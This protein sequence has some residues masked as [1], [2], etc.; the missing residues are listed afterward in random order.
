MA[1]SSGRRIESL[2]LALGAER[3]ERSGAAVGFLLNGV[4]AQFHRPH[5]DKAALE[6]SGQGRPQLLGE[7]RS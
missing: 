5:P 6:V 3:T 7:S 2:F 1:T 4:F